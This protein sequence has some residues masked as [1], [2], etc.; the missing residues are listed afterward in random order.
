M[1]YNPISDYGIIGNMSSAALVGI[2]GSI[3]WCCLPRFDSPAIFAALLDDEK[4][5]RFQIKPLGPYRSSHAYIADSNVLQ[6]TFETDEGTAVLTDFMPCYR[7][8]SGRLVRVSEIHRR[9]ECT[10]GNIE[11]AVVFQPALDYA[12]S[13][14][15]LTASI[16]GVSAA[17]GNSVL[18]LSATVPLEV[19]DNGAGGSVTLKQGENTSF[20]LS[21]GSAKS[22][23]ITVFRM[24]TRLKSTISYW[25]E[26]AA[27]CAYTGRWREEIIR[28][29]LTL[30][31]LVYAPSG[32]IIAAPTTSLPEDIGGER[33]WDY[34]YAWLRDASFTLN[35]F[36]RLGHKEEAVGFMKFL[37]RAYNTNGQ[38]TQIL[39]NINFDDMGEERTL[40]HL[41]GYRQSTPVRIGNNA[42]KQLQLDVFGEVLDA[43][44]NFVDIGGYIG[45]RD[46]EL[47]ESFVNTACESWHQPDNGIWEVRGGPFHFVHSN[48][49]CWVAVDRGIKLAGQLGYPADLER[50][51][52]A[53]IDIREDI[54]KKGWDP[55][56]GSFTQHY[57]TKTLDASNLLMPLFGFLPVTDEKMLSTIKATI[58]KLSGRDGLLRRYL[59]AETDDGLSGEEGMFL[60]CS[61]WLVRIFIRLG[62]LAEAE[63]LYEKL[64][65][66]TNQL[67]LCSEMV[68]P[69]SGEALGNFPQA[70]SHLAIIIAG[71]ELNQALQE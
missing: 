43:V 62:R 46:W 18:A 12:R 54:M 70:L 41:E 3:D 55:E 65:G 39:Y 5:G 61:F 34:R 21:Y 58:E 57:D 23:S 27:T 20:V 4:G 28:S 40:D 56:Q 71:L 10:R 63:T 25:Q 33:N 53:V 45:H 59:T 2:G 32:A 37:L 7:I 42:Y 64:L 51:H 11:L 50:W 35:A 69:V 30:H 14:T 44:S 16:H 66:Y 31:L 13:D 15:R 6:T 48:M 1:I 26:Q 47:L 60:W 29:Y 24:E 38:K 49:M 36:S 68:D 22:Q 67:K 8:P 9:L 52:Q 17:D 19:R